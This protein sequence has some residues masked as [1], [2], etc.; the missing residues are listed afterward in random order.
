VSEA[1]ERDLVSVE[2]SAFERLSAGV[3]LV[4]FLTVVLGVATLFGWVPVEQAVGGLSLFSLFG[5]AM[6][7]MGASVLGLGATSRAGLFETD[8]D[9][10]SGLVTGSLFGVIWFVAAGL[11]AANTFGLGGRAWYTVAPLA[12]L[13]TLAGTVLLREDV[14]ST[15]PVGVPVATAG[16]AV[17]TGLVGPGWTW[18]P[19]G[20]SVTVPAHVAV[21]VLAVLC[22][23]L[24]GWTAGKAYS[25][26]GTRGRQTGAY[27]LV[28]LV[29]YAVLGV[30]VVLVGF[31]AARGLAPVLAN[32][33]VGA[34]A[35]LL[36]SGVALVLVGSRVAST[37]TLSTD[38]VTPRTLAGVGIL[39]VLGVAGLVCLGVLVTKQPVSWSGVTVAP[40][41]RV[42][43]GVALLALAV[44]TLFAW[45]RYDGVS[46]LHTRGTVPR[47]VRVALLV[48][49]LV[50]TSLVGAGLVTSAADAVL[51]LVVAPLASGLAVV[52]AAYPTALLLWRLS[53]GG[54]VTDGSVAPVP[55]LK[56]GVAGGLGFLALAVGFE[57]ASGLVAVGSPALPVG[58]RLVAVA[59]A[60]QTVAASLL[61]YAVVVGSAGRGTTQA[62]EQVTLAGVGVLGALTLLVGHAV[63]TFNELVVFGLVTVSPF[64]ALD[65]PFLM[66]PSQGLGIQTGVMPAVIGTVWLVGGAVLM[67]VPLAVGA[68]VYLTEYAEE[69]LVTRG[70]E[71]ATNG[72]WS[73]P[74]IVFGLF[75]LAF[76]V[77][78]FGNSPSLFAG[79]LVLSFMLLPLVLIT[80]REAMKAV[81]DEY[82]DASAALGVSKWQT[83]RSVVVPAAMP[84]VI[85]GVILGVGRIAGETAPLIIVLRG[86][87]FPSQGPGVLGS[88]DVSFG[89]QPPFV[90]VANPAL[91]DRASALPFQLYAVITAGVGENQD[92]AWGTALVL[93]GVV[94]SFY[95]VGIISR[96]YFRRKLEQ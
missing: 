59:V 31:I 1:Y 70:V 4:A 85:T 78:R 11:I 24:S 69:S 15:L 89:L 19:A 88:F 3:V 51:G 77:P 90:H 82:R 74:S 95:A 12:G 9:Q 38:A 53:A 41:G 75:G 67:A 92:F 50:L 43:T 58:G 28:S 5:V 60:A 61:V 18:S 49:G 79:Q 26:F 23:L 56:L 55:E 33:R 83:I 66:N 46:V 8:P 52:L 63:V 72:L 76:I 29:V 30:L 21:P 34:A 16:V 25:G 62:R 93:L 45:G 86:A 35:G 27:L 80:S 87:N 36:V 39:S 91:L 54:D 96:R 17:V 65:W 6:L 73:T 68:A 81:P 84:G 44:P 42:G 20:L 10:L 2:S 94:L 71:L 57:A 40:V 47:Y 22:S 7:A 37:A 48:V 64:G 32:L 13:A 14:G